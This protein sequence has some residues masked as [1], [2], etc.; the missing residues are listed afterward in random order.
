MMSTASRHVGDGVDVGGSVQRGV[1]Q[2]LVVPGATG[3]RVVAG[4]ALELVVAA[5]ALEHVDTGVADDGLR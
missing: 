4:H 3:E 1:E 2:E 5:E